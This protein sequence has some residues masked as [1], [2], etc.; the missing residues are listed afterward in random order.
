VLRPEILRQAF[1]VEA[2]VVTAPDGSCVVVPRIT[3]DPPDRDPGAGG[4]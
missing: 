2:Y 4:C 1:G 3:A